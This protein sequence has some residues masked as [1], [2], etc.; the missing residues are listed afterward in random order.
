GPLTAGQAINLATAASGPSLEEAGWVEEEY[1]A[2]GTATS[3]R[4]EGELLADGTYAL[5]EDA[6]ADYATRVV[7]RRRADAEGF[8]GTGVVERLNV[9]GGL[10]AAPDLAY[11]ADE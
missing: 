2:P 11:M 4:A 5:V 8:N 1:R 6:R 9:S 10:D 3:Y 7:V